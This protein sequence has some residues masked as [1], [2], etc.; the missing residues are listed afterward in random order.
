MMPHAMPIRLSKTYLRLLLAALIAC[1][2]VLLA[3][4][5][6][7]P[8]R[9]HAP[10]SYSIEADKLRALDPRQQRY[11]MVYA[12]IDPLEAF[13]TRVQLIRRAQHSIDLAYYIWD[14]DTT[15]RLILHELIDAAQRGVRVRLLLD[16]QNTAGLDALWLAV[17]QQPNLEVRLFNPFGYRQQRL[18]NHLVDFSRTQRRLHGKTFVV[19]GQIMIV[20]GRNMGDSYYRVS[21]DYFFADLDVMIAGSAL[22]PMGQGFDQFWNDQLAYPVL[23]LLKHDAAAEQ[24]ALQQIH[25]A[26]QAADAK[27]Y[28]DAIAEQHPLDRWLNGQ[29][30]A[31]TLL[32]M[33]SLPTR[34]TFVTDLPAKVHQPLP[35]AQTIGAQILT[36]AGDTQ[37]SLDIVSPYLVPTKIGTDALVKLAQNGIRI[38]ILTNSLA[39]TDVTVVHDFYARRR[40]QLLAAGVQLYEFKPDAHA[41]PIR[42]WRNRETQPNARSGL[43]AKAISWDGHMTYVGSMNL[44]PRSVL[45]NAEWGVMV[46][47]SEAADLVDQVF[48]GNILRIAYQV[49]LD[50]DGKLIW[51]EKTPIGE[52]I[53]H[54]SEP[55][56][57]SRRT[58]SRVAGWLPIEGLM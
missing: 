3:A 48:S 28:L 56:S 43:H 21:P 29:Q 42:K 6:T 15:G 19:D 23:G 35:F 1:C 39:A 7:L 55:A 26:Q 16:D 33:Q 47:S 50:R 54:R 34:T 17:A 41:D 2:I 36:I 10:L 30:V 14:D 37:Q 25:S 12:L 22:R 58:L 20:G 49:T 8:T 45:I 18:L 11:D 51:L 24:M 13:A 9:P 27:I 31:S 46:D 57:R 38:R 53:E 40:Q 4:C 52:M 32:D 5:N 44:D